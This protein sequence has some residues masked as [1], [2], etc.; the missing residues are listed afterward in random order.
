MANLD[1]TSFKYNELKIKEGDKITF[2]HYDRI[3]TKKVQIV[4]VQD[5]NGITSYNVNPIGSGTGWLG[6]SPYEVINI[7]RK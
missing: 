6:V 1:Y 4:S 2:K 7:K 3:Y 5:F